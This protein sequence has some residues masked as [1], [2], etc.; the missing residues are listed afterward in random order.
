MEYKTIDQIME[1]ISELVSGKKPNGKILLARIY[2]AYER[3]CEAVEK[4]KSVKNAIGDNR[5]NYEIHMISDDMYIVE[6][7]EDIFR[8]G[9]KNWFAPYCGEPR[10]KLSNTLYKTFDGA[11]IGLICM[12]MGC[13]NA[14]PYIFRMLN[15]TSED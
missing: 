15:M 6:Y 10:K 2:G 13:E 3:E 12:K 7:K 5:R 4:E 14:V 9:K 1:Y 8:D 11:L